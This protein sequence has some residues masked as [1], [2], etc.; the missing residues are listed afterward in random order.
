[1]EYLLVMS[2][3]GSTMIGIYLLL[4]WLLKDKVSA[5]LYYLLIKEAV[6]FF[7]IPLPFL[8]G[9]Y[10]QV[11]RTVIPVGQMKRVEIPVAWTRY[12]IREGEKTY[13][14]AYMGVQMIMLAV[15][16][17]IVCIM[18]MRPLIKYLRKIGRASCRERV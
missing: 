3:S 8:K 1:M 11:I 9:W 17:F 13:V 16:L 2:L 12:V 18:M 5:R 7:L 15:W 6:L 14:N 4:K 10:R